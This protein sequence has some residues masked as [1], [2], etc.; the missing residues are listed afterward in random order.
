M[1]TECVFCCGLPDSI[2]LKPQ[3]CDED[4]DEDCEEDKDCGHVV[5]AAQLGMFSYIIQ[6][7]L[8]C[9]HTNTQHESNVHKLVSQG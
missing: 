7:V 5:H 8:H 3:R 1:Y 2:P 4:V 9:W 6:I